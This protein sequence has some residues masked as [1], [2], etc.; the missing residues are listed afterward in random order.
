MIYLL[1]YI[2]S[3]VIPLVAFIVWNKEVTESE[4]N[5]FSPEVTWWIML[6]TAFCPI[7]NT[8]FVLIS[9]AK[10]LNERVPIYLKIIWVYVKYFLILV[11]NKSQRRLYN[12]ARRIKSIRDNKCIT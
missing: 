6:F 3:A 7:I 8:G 2:I 1:V 5:P 11:F 10:Y 12:K 4:E 9:L